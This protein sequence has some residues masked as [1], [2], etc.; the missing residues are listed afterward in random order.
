[1]TR[2]KVLMRRAALLIALAL[3]PPVAALA[4]ERPER[5][6]DLPRQ[7]SALPDIEIKASVKAR[8]LKFEQVG[9]ASVE[10]PGKPRRKTVSEFDR[11]NLPDPVSPGVV[12]RDIDVRLVITTTFDEILRA[13]T[14]ALGLPAT[15]AAKNTGPPMLLA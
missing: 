9:N 6:P 4:Q 7:S 15:K 3:A 2:Y 1:M 14:G 10:F 12:Y 11:G 13:I 5:P 8:E